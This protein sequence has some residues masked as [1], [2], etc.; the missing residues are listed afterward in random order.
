MSFSADD[1]VF[2]NN[3]VQLVTSRTALLDADLFVTRRATR[4][5]DPN[6]TVGVFAQN[7][8]PDE[9]SH[10]M[11]G[12]DHAHMPTLSTYRVTV[13][14]LVRDIDEVRGLAT[15]A[16]MSRAIRS[17]LYNDAPLRV[18]LGSL[19][20]SDS[21]TTERSRRWG[22]ANQR[23]FVNE[24]AGDWLYLSILEFWLETETH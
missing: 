18:A 5:T 1:T 11:L 6:Q 13:Q 9:Q 3:I 14:A 24:I 20:S 17:M 12:Q 15:H 2:P 8:T 10:E 23:F 16:T 22:V 19:A 4:A 21:G 7:W